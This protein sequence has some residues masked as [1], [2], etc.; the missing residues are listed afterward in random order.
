MS[1]SIFHRRE[2]LPPISRLALLAVVV[3]AGCASQA[4]IESVERPL[5][6][7]GLGVNAPAVRDAKSS[8]EAWWTAMG[9]PKLDQLVQQALAD[10]PSIRVA[11][12]RLVRAQA[13]A[14]YLRGSELPQIQAKGEVDRQRYSELGLFPPPL[15]GHPMTFSTL[16]LEG[17]WELDLFGKKRSELD[18]AIG[19]AKASAA[20]LESS[21]L[22]LSSQV[23]KAYVQL[24]RLVAQ[25]KVLDRLLAQREEVLGLVKQ[26]V[27]AGLDTAVELK[28][29]EGALPEARLQR[30]MVNEQI[31]LM[32]HA[33]A[34]LVGAGPQSLN[35]LSPDLD[36]IKPASIPQHVP[37]DLL[38][39]RAD[40]QAALWRV[41]ASGDQVKAARALFYPNI[42]LA[43]YGG[44]NARGLEHL[45][46]TGTQ[47][48]G[49]MPAVTLPLFDGGLRRSNLQGKVAESDAAVA[50]YNQT[51]LG[52]VR[53]A[54]DQVSSLLA[55]ERQKQEQEKAQISAESAYDLAL[56]RY[57]AGLGTYLTVL[58][59]ESA[60]LAQR[61]ASVDL[62]ARVLDTQ[63]S[64]VRA[65]GGAVSGD[66][67]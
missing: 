13:A 42:D 41:E 10:S 12:A 17:S 25:R 21:R 36:A 40:V 63:A 51:V 30:E 50:A 54:S 16:Q 20:D 28:Q 22:L 62:K 15:S 2:G 39:R 61:R 33:L 47:Q 11:Q 45:L 14:G 23:V 38:S 67:S 49:V 32:R 65:M 46:D 55:I 5:S 8:T 31:E 48:W 6:A 35:D 24:G 1:S 27:Q 57:R 43:V 37:I 64:M 18:A 59:S 9:D 34:E 52:A 56:Q 19:Q 60:V 3:L 66:H 58:T 4:G 53:D 44:F 26:R 29:G 7:D